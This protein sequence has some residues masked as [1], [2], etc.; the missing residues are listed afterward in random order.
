MSRL[1]TLLAAVLI[2]TACGGSTGD[3]VDMPATDPPG[4][5]TVAAP[6][7]STPETSPPNE[8]PAPTE[9]PAASGDSGTGHPMMVPPATAR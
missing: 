5:A 6:P 7:P 9:A 8:A 4:N 2:V 3:A 1:K